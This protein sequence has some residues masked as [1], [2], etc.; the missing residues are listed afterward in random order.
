MKFPTFTHYYAEMYGV[1]VDDAARR[2]ALADALR[3]HLEA[4][5]SLCRQR[6]CTHVDRS[7]KEMKRDSLDAYIWRGRAQE[8]DEWPDAFQHHIEMIDSLATGYADLMK[9]EATSGTV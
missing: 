4:M 9:E 8:A 5:R 6:Y 2:I 7:A 1:S 3:P